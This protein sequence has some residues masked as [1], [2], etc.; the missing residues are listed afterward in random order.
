[1][2]ATRRAY[3][4]GL[5]GLLLMAGGCV[6]PAPQ[7]ADWSA[8]EPTHEPWTRWWWMGNAVDEQTL[9]QLLTTYDEAG[10]GG[11]WRSR[12]STG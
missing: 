3:L 7:A 1:M 2:R 12:Q 4:V 5:L 10:L 8:I 9:T 11:G 6:E